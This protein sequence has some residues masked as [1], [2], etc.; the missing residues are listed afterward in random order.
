MSAPTGLQ[1]FLGGVDAILGIRDATGLTKQ[2]VFFVKRTWFSDSG[3]T[4]PSGGAEGYATD[5]V[6]QLLPTPGIKNFSQDIR[7]REG[8]AVKSGDIILTGVSGNRFT[9]GQL[10]GSSSA[11]NVENLFLVGGK[12]YQV[13]N[14]TK[15]YVT[16][17]VQLREL[18]N[19][20]RY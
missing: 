8:G 18:S 12:L 9:E 6:T 14:V 2:P 5:A 20:T 16:F 10:D 3:K 15:K 11:A 13:I 4:N 17:Q 19:Q 7:L 1:G